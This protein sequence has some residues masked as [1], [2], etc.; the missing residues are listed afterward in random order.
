MPNSCSI[1]VLTCAFH[2]NR[3]LKSAG[4]YPDQAIKD[5]LQMKIVAKHTAGDIPTVLRRL[6]NVEAQSLRA[7]YA[8]LPEDRSDSLLGKVMKTLR[9]VKKIDAWIECDCPGAILTPVESM[10]PA[11]PH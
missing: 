11:R 10:R 5:C 9:E 3:H 8:T 2:A 1:R 4:K 7:F 6:T